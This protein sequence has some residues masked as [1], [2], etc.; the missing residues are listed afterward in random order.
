MVQEACNHVS[1][2]KIP[3]LKASAQPYHQSKAVNKGMSLPLPDYVTVG[4][5]LTHLQLQFFHLQK[6]KK[7]TL[8]P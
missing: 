6:G 3:M 2:H 1:N 5:F 8:T 7:T 4:R